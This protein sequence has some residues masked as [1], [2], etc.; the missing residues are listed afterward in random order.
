MQTNAKITPINSIIKT[1]FDEWYSFPSLEKQYVRVERTD[2]ADGSPKKI[3]QKHSLDFGTT[4]KNDKNGIVTNFYDLPKILDSS[5]HT[6]FL[7]EGELKTVELSAICSNG[8]HATT[9]GGTNSWNAKKS[10]IAKNIFK[11]KTV[12][13]LP[14]NDKPGKDFAE[15]VFRD[16][17]TNNIDAYIVELPGLEEKEDVWNF[18]DNRR[19]NGA[20]N[21]TIFNEIKSICDEKKSQ[22]TSNLDDRLSWDQINQITTGKNVF[23]AVDF[24]LKQNYKAR[25]NVVLGKN[26]IQDENGNFKL[27]EEREFLKLWKD[28]NQNLNVK[29]R[30]SKDVLE[31]C[32]S[33]TPDFD[34][35]KNWAENLK[36]TEESKYEIKLFELFG[37]IELENKDHTELFQTV[38]KKWL[39]GCY[40]Q[41]TLRKNDRGSAIV[42]DICPVLSGGQGI[43]KNSLIDKI[44]SSIGY[45]YIHT[46]SLD[47]SD[48]D[49]LKMIS[50]MAIIHMD[51]F[52]AT[53]KKADVSFLKN[54]ISKSTITQRDPYARKETTRNRRASFI[55]SINDSVDILKDQTGNRRFPTFRI[56]SIKLDELR[57]FDMDQLWYEIKY[58]AE[59]EN[60]SNTLSKEEIK[61]I[62]IN[63]EEFVTNDP[64]KDFIR[65]NFSKERTDS[66]TFEQKLS[67]SNILEKWVFGQENNPNITHASLFQRE[68]LSS[69]QLQN[70]L[71][72][73]LSNLG[74]TKPPKQGGINLWT[75]WTKEATP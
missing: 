15:K 35:F 66:R 30:I 31:S 43:G 11:N 72:R 53:T 63:N 45:D 65:A 47:P 68:N 18:I 24:V 10:E 48:K 75:I 13:I 2:F 57:N 25:T 32:L 42:N 55:A 61:Q 19:K 41:A 37:L 21:N 27:V 5:I 62:E 40:N 23:D 69:T 3:Y 16:L 67:V 71:G 60:F 26:E 9:T 39:V 1:N 54:Q 28:F 59:I 49:S 4:W 46:S 34:P 12:F 58:L 22:L 51:E 50:C 17:R 7:C 33:D 70:R 20:N 14:D 36:I 74:Y 56:K 38:M 8:Y 29:G 64:F 44:G 6:A 52:D 73:A